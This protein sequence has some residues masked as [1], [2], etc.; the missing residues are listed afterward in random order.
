[1]PAV[2]ASVIAPPRPAGAW[3]EDRAYY[4]LTALL[5]IASL[6]MAQ[7]P[8][9]FTWDYVGQ[10]NFEVSGTHALIAKLQW[11]PLF[12]LGLG[13]VALRFRLSMALL[14]HLNPFLLAAVL[15]CGLTTFWSYDP[16]FTSRRAFKLMLIM[17][18]GFGFIV[19]SWRIDRF[20]HLLRIGI[21]GFLVGSLLFIAAFPRLGIHQLAEVE[22]DLA[23]AWRGLSTHKNGLGPV[24]AIGLILWTHAWMRGRDPSL[25]VF[26]MLVSAVCLIGSR[27][28]T[29]LACALICLM[30]IAL[31]LKTR[32]LHRPGLPAFLFVTLLLVPA[33]AF[34]VLYGIPTQ[35]ELLSP[36]TT[37]LGRDLTFTGR[38]YL[39]EGLLNEI[40][41]H[42]WAGIGFQAFWRGLDSASGDAMRAA[43]F[44]VNQGHNGYL[45]T[46]NE[47]GIIGLVLVLSAIA[48]DLRRAWRFGAI[49]N[50]VLAI[51][52]S[53]QVYQLL[54]N[55]SETQFLRTISLTCFL[56]VLSSFHLSRISLQADLLRRAGHGKGMP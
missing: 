51:H 2:P 33:A 27:S 52:L 10:N 24:A 28:S 29:A 37:A 1:M 15:W 56:W 22:P 39:W 45:D 5:V 11:L 17:F 18:I 55:L 7:L 54:V 8:D 46:L 35:K 47:L 19:A 36:L 42:P 14:P 38:I 23:G 49:S 12:M 32:L 13:L 9:A 21:L 50:D 25:A 31:V 43:G 6:F 26:A 16:G 53:L 48:L 30:V 3:Q 34:I 44:V 41:K 4:L 40:P 20:E